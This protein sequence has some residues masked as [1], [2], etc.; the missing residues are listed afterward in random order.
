[1]SW[2]AVILSLLL[3]GAVASGWSLWSQR[4]QET[5]NGP[6]SGRPDYVL[7]DFEMVALDEQG[8]ESFT[9]RAP[10]LARDPGDETFAITTPLFLIPASQGANGDSWKVRSR[11]A[12]VSPDGDE[13]RLRGDVRATSDGKAGA[14]VKITTDHLTVFP[15]AGRAAT[16]A[17]V[18]VVQPGSILRGRGLEV[19]FDSTRYTLKSEV[20]S[21]YVP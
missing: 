4:Q 20:H 2:R 9:L 17:V 5:V 19:G 8:N 6:A 18:T 14:P 11:T 7:H 1:M 21:R 12:W 3:L 13:L 10:R 16:S 15:Q